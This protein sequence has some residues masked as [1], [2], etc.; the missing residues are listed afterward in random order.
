MHD[1]HVYMLKNIPLVSPFEI[2]QLLKQSKPTRLLDLA[3]IAVCYC[4]ELPGH[5]Q[6]KIQIAKLQALAHVLILK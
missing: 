4:L 6:A 5:E 1:G 2:N 3:N